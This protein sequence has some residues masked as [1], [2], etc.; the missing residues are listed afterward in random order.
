MIANS[1]L[2]NYSQWMGI[3]TLIAAVFTVLGFVLKWVFR[4]RLVGVT[5][6]MGVLTIGI[7]ALS[8]GLYTRAEIPGAIPYTLVYDNGGVKTVIAVPPTVNESELEATMRQAGGDL[9]SFGR[10][11][12]ITNLM[13]I[14]VRTILHPQT[15]VS[16]PVYLGEVR[17]SLSKREDEKMA[18]DIFPDAIARL[19]ASQV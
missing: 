4:F 7:F 9:F 19:K 15:G 12:G 6:F 16:L 13:T 18:I 11:G 2:L 10:G 14:R 3:L 5:G 1:D 17:R 8:L